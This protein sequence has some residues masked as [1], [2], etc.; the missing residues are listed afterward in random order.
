VCSSDLEQWVAQIWPDLKVELQVSAFPETWW[1]GTL[2]YMS[3]ALREGTRDLLVEATVAN[4]EQK[5]RPGM[6]AVARVILPL[7]ETTVVPEQSVRVDGE[8]SR[9]FVVRDGLLEERI[10]ELGTR[11]TPWVEVRRGVSPGD[12]VVSPFSVEAKDGAPIARVDQTA[13]K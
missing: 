4:A 12:S 9:L 1:P 8:L 10:V 3:A 11:Q 13:Q 5:L 7:A 2:R 6:F